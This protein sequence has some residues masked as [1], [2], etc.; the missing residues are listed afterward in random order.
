[1]ISQKKLIPYFSLMLFLNFFTV[2]PSKLLKYF[3]AFSIEEKDNRE[4][5]LPVIMLFALSTSLHASRNN[6]H[7]RLSHLRNF[8]TKFCLINILHFHENTLDKPNF[9]R[10]IIS[11]SKWLFNY[12]VKRRDEIPRASTKKVTIYLLAKAI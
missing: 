6:V 10:M 8:K 5:M 12:F 4:S 11:F 3:S 7:I 1:M 9:Q 2:T